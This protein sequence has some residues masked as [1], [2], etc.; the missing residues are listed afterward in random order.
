M[1]IKIK[2]QA[3]GTRILSSE[4]AAHYRGVID[5]LSSMA[6]DMDA[7]ELILP[8]I[9]PVS[10][11][12]DRLDLLPHLYAFPQRGGGRLCLRPEGTATCQLIAESAWRARRNVRTFFVAKCWRYERPQL[13]HHY[14]FTQF[15]FE[16]L[17]PSS[18]CSDWVEKL[19]L[20]MVQTFTKDCV[21]SPA[22]IPRGMTP[23]VN[24][25][26]FQITCEQLAARRQVCVGGPYRQG[27]GFEISVDR[28]MLI[29]ELSNGIT[30]DNFC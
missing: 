2:Q 8:C 18:P 29:G 3:R 13:G 11:Y 14:E 9:E 5:R 16:V 4:T 25:F 12:D 17:N 24:G 23:A 19:A 27:C 6:K 20:D 21:L 7:Q 22:A 1:E 28:I 10:I 26:A 15:G 30:L